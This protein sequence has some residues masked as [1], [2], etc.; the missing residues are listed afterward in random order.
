MKITTK[1]GRI[2]EVKCKKITSTT[3]D[4]YY[5][6]YSYESYDNYYVGIARYRN[7][8]LLL[9]IKESCIESIEFEQGYDNEKN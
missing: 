6:V 5:E 3:N 4:E 7:K 2:H 9:K 8:N 1:S